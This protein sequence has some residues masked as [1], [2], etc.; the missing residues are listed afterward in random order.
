MVIHWREKRRAHCMFAADACRLVHER[1]SITMAEIAQEA[2]GSESLLL[3]IS[4]LQVSSTCC[5]AAAVLYV[6]ACRVRHHLKK[7]LQGIVCMQTSCLA[8]SAVA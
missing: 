3:L 1:L 8:C 4:R 5:V 7:C 6:W 2:V